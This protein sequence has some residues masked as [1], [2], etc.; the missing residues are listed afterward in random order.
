LL[1]SL[2][3]TGRVWAV[4]IIANKPTV[5]YTAPVK[6]KKF[7]VLHSNDMHGDLFADVFTESSESDVGSLRSGS[8]RSK[9]LGPTVTLRDILECFPYNDSL[10]RVHVKGEQ[11]WNIF[12]H[13]MRKK[14][15]DGEGECYQVNSGIKAVY[16]D[17]ENRLLSLNISGKP[18]DMEKYYTLCLQGYHYTNCAEFLGISQEDFMKNGKWKVVTTSARE[19]L[20]EYLK[21]GQNI[22][23]KVEGRF[24]YY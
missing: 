12:T 1:H 17:A 18:V 7:T 10:S 23:R 24:I 9:T 13:I 22:G 15:R 4:G 20:E 6:T 2:W 5:Y 14:N 19:V 21:T 11:L 16:S 3:A 8:I